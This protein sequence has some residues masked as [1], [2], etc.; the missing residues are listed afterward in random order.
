MSNS[1]TAITLS[2][3]GYEGSLLADFLAT[4]QAASVTR[5]LP[6]P[7]GYVAYEGIVETDRWFGPLFTNLRLTRTD[8]P[9]RLRADYPLIQ[10]QPLPRTLY[11]DDVLADMAIAGTLKDFSAQDWADYNTSI[12]EPSSRPNRPFGSYAV[13]GRKRRK[14]G[15]PVG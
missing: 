7:G 11:T 4:M 9:I 6:A 14:S 12:A 8:S 10:V 15:C 13:D 5:N 1:R 2:T 3:V